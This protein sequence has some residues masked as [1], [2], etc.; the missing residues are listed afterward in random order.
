MP[1]R[2]FGGRRVLEGLWIL[3][4]LYV[5][6]L[7]RKLRR[8]TGVVSAEDV[9]K[10]PNKDVFETLIE[11]GMSPRAA[12]RSA[13]VGR[14]LKRHIIR[15]GLMLVEV[16]QNNAVLEAQL[17]RHTDRAPLLKDY[18][19]NRGDFVQVGP[20]CALKK[21][22]QL[23]TGFVNGGGIPHL[24]KWERETQQTASEFAHAFL[25]EQ[26]LLRRI[27]MQDP[28]SLESLVFEKS[29]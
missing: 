28:A 8:D 25:E 5:P 15:A 22:K 4:V 24:Q 13:F 1:K 17:G 3:F 7:P 16:D 26:R 2:R 10:L 14:K 29:K 11:S 12:T 23:Y 9:D 27:D 21:A 18:I 19:S 20:T 6:N